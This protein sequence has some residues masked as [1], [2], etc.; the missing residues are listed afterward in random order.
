[1]VILN[2]CPFYFHKKRRKKD[3]ALQHGSQILT[4]QI[5]EL[6]VK[7]I[8]FLQCKYSGLPEKQN[9]GSLVSC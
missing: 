4:T 3:I 7:V 9:P 1:M 8:V 6:S 2:P 5:L